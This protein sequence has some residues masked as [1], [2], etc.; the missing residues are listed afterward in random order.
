MILDLFLR[1]HFSVVNS[2]SFLESFGP[3]FYRGNAN[4]SAVVVLYLEDKT[5]LKSSLP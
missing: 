4:S 1:E 3:E 5:Q 2:G